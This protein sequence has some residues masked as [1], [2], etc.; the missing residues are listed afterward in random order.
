[1]LKIASRTLTTFNDP[2]SLTISENESGWNWGPKEFKISQKHVTRENNGI[3]SYHSQRK[4]VKFNLRIKSKLHYQP[5]DDDA[6]TRYS[7]IACCDDNDA[8][9]STTVIRSDF[10][11]STTT[12]KQIKGCKFTTLS[13][14]NKEL[15]IATQINVHLFKAIS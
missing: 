7:V 4:F 2:N 13:S 8:E 9:L 14:K 3:C 10:P 11:L 15:S 1:M 5:C 6:I 12:W